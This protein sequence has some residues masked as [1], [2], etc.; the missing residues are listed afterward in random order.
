MPK[1]HQCIGGPLDGEFATSYDFYGT[2]T[3]TAGRE[4]G[5]Y[6]HLKHEY[7]QFNTARHGAARTDVVWL[8]RDTLR[9][10]ISPRER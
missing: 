2:W 7:F 3:K 10:S 1:A 9:P 5:M 4:E 6:E 8:H